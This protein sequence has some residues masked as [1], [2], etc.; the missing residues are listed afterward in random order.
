MLSRLLLDVGQP[1]RRCDT[2]TEETYAVYSGATCHV[3]KSPSV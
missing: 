3:G 1:Y 2:L